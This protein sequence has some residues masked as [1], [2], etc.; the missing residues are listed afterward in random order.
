[1]AGDDEMKKAVCRI[2]IIVLIFCIFPINTY[3]TDDMLQKAEDWLKHGTKNGPLISD[4]TL[5][6]FIMP[7]GRMLM[8]IAIIILVIVT[9][10]MGIKYITLSNNP[11]EQAKLK[12]QLIGLV[13]SAVVIFGA[14]LIWSMVY[15]LFN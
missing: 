2:L 12:K 9:T 10:I 14:Q 5:Q 4:G 7:I 13:I 1:M 11:D 3:A 8:V 6:S 15:N